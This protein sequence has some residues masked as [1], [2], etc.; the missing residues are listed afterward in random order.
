VNFPSGLLMTSGFVPLGVSLAVHEKVGAKDRQP[1]RSHMAAARFV[2]AWGA[3]A[4]LTVVMTAVLAGAAAAVP[5]ATAGILIDLAARAPPGDRP[6][7]SAVP[8]GRP[9]P[10]RPSRRP[11]TDGGP[12]HPPARPTTQALPSKEREHMETLS[13]TPATAN[14]LASARRSECCSY[15]ERGP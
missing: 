2:L 1:G 10:F 5:T 11:T 7:H 15:A 8:P 4:P 9:S 12:M 6:C 3:P 14:L 13:L